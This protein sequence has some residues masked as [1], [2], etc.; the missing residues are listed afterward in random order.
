MDQSSDGLA[1]RH[2]HY[3]AECIQ[4]ENHNGELIIAAHGD[5]RGIH[6]SE[7]FGEHLQVGDLAV[8]DRIREAERVLIV[9]AVHAGPTSISD[10]VSKFKGDK[11]NVETYFDR[12]N[13]SFV[14]SS[15]LSPR[16][17]R[18]T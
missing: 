11:Q 9:D 17:T 7:G 16:T 8:A 18:T 5:C 4:I 13:S 12:R 14:C 2:T 6:D 15:T 3:I 1:H 10:R